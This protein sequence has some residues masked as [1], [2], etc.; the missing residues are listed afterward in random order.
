[1]RL[2]IP[3]STIALALL[4]SCACSK[5][6]GPS[7]PVVPG[8]SADAGHRDAGHADASTTPEKRLRLTIL[9]NNDG[10]S[11]LINAG[12]GLEEYGGIA[13]FATLVDRLRTAA[14]TGTAADFNHEALVLSS[15]DNV[16]PG[17]ELQASLTKGVPFYDSIAMSLIG[18]DALCLGNHDFDLGPDI[19][20]DLIGGVTTNAPFVSANLDVALEARLQALVDSGRLAKRSI[21]TLPSGHRVGIIGLTTDTLP[22]ISA[23]R[24]VVVDGNFATVVAREVTALEA[25]NVDKIILL[26]HLQDIARDVALVRELSGVDVI[27]SGGGDELLANPGDLL[28]PGD[29]N[30]IAGPYPFI[31]QD[32]DGASVPI[33]TTAGSYKYVGRLVIEFD[34]A[35]R[36]VQIAST[37]GAVRV[38]GGAQ[39][40][41]VPDDPNV[42]TQVLDPIVA[43]LA[44]LS[45]NVLAQSEVALNGVRGDVRSRE[46]NLGNLV[47]DAL[48]WHA[49]QLAPAH[50]LPTPNVGLVNGGGIR[51][52]SLIPAGNITELTT[53][54]ILPFPSFL[55][56]VPNVPAARLKQIIDH[57]VA[58]AGGGA[59]LHVS[60]I[61]LTYSSQSG[62]RSIQLS[63]GT[64]LVANGQV[65][66]N[67]PAV[68]IST[69]SF[70]A[71]GGG[72]AP[73]GDAPFTNIGAAYQ[74]SLAGFIA[75]T[76]GLNGQ[77]TAAAY[78]EAG[79]GRIVAR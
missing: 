68:T 65:V 59:F 61:Q 17:A 20:A 76:N 66:A 77:I 73:F 36:L 13:R 46:T 32:R 11:Q 10:E 56:V 21:I 35:G 45:T 31:G 34:D 51:N 43:A 37:S 23:P 27:I 71:Q 53:F 19:L 39:P 15:G 48:V 40:D 25:A 5:G 74:Q 54:D 7:T 14:R 55:T 52:D 24:N 72:G 2:R 38:A 44:G 69:L 41:A 47:A 3:H 67:A 22:S 79:S 64:M 29:E 26:T 57:S 18:Y 42:K 75:A 12:A 9:H 28:V 70:L 62:V 16:L 60:G 30:A 1:M 63:D 78:P 4:C 49:T 58:N 50:Q 8:H 33:V 6:T